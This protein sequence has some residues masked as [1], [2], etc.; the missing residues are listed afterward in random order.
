MLIRC[1]CEA[2]RPAL[3]PCEE[4]ARHYLISILH[5]P[6]CKWHIVRSAQLALKTPSGKCSCDQ[7]LFNVYESHYWHEGEMG[8]LI[9]AQFE[10]GKLLRKDK[11]KTIKFCLRVTLWEGNSKLS[12][13]KLLRQVIKGF[14]VKTEWPYHRLVPNFNKSEIVRI[15]IRK[16]SLLSP[17][18]PSKDRRVDPEEQRWPCLAQGIIFSFLNNEKRV[19]F[20]YLSSLPSRSN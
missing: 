8:L 3:P 12:S 5:I 9:Y 15:D 20:V 17:K 16:R 13:W 14:G 11:I 1:V 6:R 2:V 18:R 19:C 4:T 10:K 7:R